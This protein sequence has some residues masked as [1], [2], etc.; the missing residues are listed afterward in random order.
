MIFLITFATIKKLIIALVAIIIGYAIY[1]NS[2]GG[3]EGSDGGIWLV[4]N[5]DV[6]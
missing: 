4:D 1:Y 2:K 6:I 5:Q 3:D